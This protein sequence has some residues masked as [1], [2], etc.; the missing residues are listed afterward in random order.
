MAK[1][2]ETPAKTTIP[3]ESATP[4]A[5]KAPK[6]PEQISEPEPSAASTPEQEPEPDQPPAPEA[7]AE[8]APERKPE[9]DQSPALEVPGTTGYLRVKGEEPPQ[10]PAQVTTWETPQAQTAQP[11]APK[12]LTLSAAAELYRVPS[13]QSAALH[14][15]MGWE[16][17][18]NVT[19]EEYAAALVRLKNRRLGG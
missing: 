3:E 16:P 7:S 14:K 12:L 6:A 19:V 15:L 10:T 13:W 2:K 11:P 4:A 5:P 8:P 18:K 9:P 1:S 17:G